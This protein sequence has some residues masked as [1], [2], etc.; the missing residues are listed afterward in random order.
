[1]RFF[2]ILFLLPLK[3]FSQDI[4]GVWTGTIYNDTTHKYI[5]YEIAITESKGRLRGFSH[6]VFMGENN[7]PETGVKTLKIKKKGE[8]ILIEDDELIYNN[9]AEPAP[10]SVK[11]YSVL[12]VIPGDSSLLLI[13]VFNTNRT[14]EYASLTGTIYLQKKIISSETKII[15]KLEELNLANSLSFLQVKQT[16]DVAIADTKKSI[17]LNQPAKQKAE[18]TISD[19]NKDIQLE[20]KQKKDVV[21]VDINNIKT[22][23][24]VITDNKLPV[25]KINLAPVEKAKEKKLL[26]LPP[27]NKKPEPQII[28]KEIV[29]APAIIK[30]EP[31]V[32]SQKIVQK[33]EKNSQPVPP[34]KEKYLRTLSSIKNTEPVSQQV[35]KT[36]IT[37]TREATIKPINTTL[38][39]EKN[40]QIVS[41]EPL[42]LQKS[43]LIASP[44]IS[45]EALAKRKI[46]TIRTVDFRSDSLMLTLYDNGEIDGDTVSIIL[47]GKTIMPKQGLST[48]AI[49]KTIYIT[50]DLGDSLQ[51]IMYAENLGSI[52]PNTGL[53]I[54][55]DGDERYEIRFAGDMQKNSAVI[56][57]RKKN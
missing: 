5:P 49:F 16:N 2:L 15:P 30:T 14:K 26:N 12:N 48:K 54:I 28:K 52:P 18:V 13:G 6:T 44:V 38:L 3:L 37:K 24:K 50:P 31:V 35:Y 10:K 53:L 56:L 27:T 33:E 47:N 42:S 46:E 36:K 9:Y 20:L 22:Q 17:Q 19:I 7:R 25:N 41:K 23:Q 34:V 39:K 43:A 21:V 4:A 45:A 29:S 57:R 51:L 32:Q 8:K 11:Q 55:Q 40:K 1:M